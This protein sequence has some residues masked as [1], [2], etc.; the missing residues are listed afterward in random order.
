M[1]EATGAASIFSKHDFPCRND[2]LLANKIGSYEIKKKFDIK[3]S[4]QL[5]TGFFESC[6]QYQLNNANF[7]YIITTRKIFDTY[8]LFVDEEDTAYDETITQ[9]NEFQTKS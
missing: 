5:K 7:K 4:L 8:E 6:S 9:V 1:N 2:E 3:I